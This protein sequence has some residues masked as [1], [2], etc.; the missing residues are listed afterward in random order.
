MTT[1]SSY[2]AKTHLPRLLRQVEQ[3]DEITITRHGVP[4]AKLVPAAPPVPVNAPA[5]VETSKKLTPREAIDA[6][7]EFR[8]GH[9]LGGL[10]L[11]ELI[12]EGRRY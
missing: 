3:G 7:L 6:I 1:V 5:S 2:E 8:K 4:V 12:D 9:S 11:R 10:T